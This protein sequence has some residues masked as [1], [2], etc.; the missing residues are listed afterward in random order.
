MG[1]IITKYNSGSLSWAEFAD[2]QAGG[3]ADE[4]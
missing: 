1:Q 4:G 2:A 3:P